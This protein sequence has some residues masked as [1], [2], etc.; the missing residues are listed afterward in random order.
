MEKMK[1]SIAS[2]TEMGIALITLSIV[3]AILVGPSNLIFLGNSVANITDLVE[4]LGSSGLAG[5][6]VTGIVLHLF[7]WCG[8]CDCKRK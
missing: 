3:A 5:L 7:G 4:N 8:F 6:I 1:A 2:V